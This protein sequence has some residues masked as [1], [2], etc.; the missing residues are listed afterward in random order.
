MEDMMAKLSSLLEQKETLTKYK[1]L[2]EME[3]EV[4]LK[5]QFARFMESIGI[6]NYKIIDEYF[7]RF[8]STVSVVEDEDM[9]VKDRMV[10]IVESDFLFDLMRL[11]TASRERELRRITKELS[12]FI[13]NAAIDAENDDSKFL[14][15]LLT[16]SLRTIADE[17]DPKENRG[18]GQPMTEAW[19]EAMK[20][21]MDTYLT[22]L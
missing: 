17:I 3:R 4:T 16:N 22:S 20:E 8:R 21:G 14:K 9:S 19:I 7:P 18:V 6:D 11:K 15:N 12:A 2:L 5:R 1:D 13:H 10:S